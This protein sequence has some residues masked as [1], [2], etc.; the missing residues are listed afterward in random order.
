MTSGFRILGREGPHGRELTPRMG[1]QAWA[2]QS[3][4]LGITRTPSLPWWAEAGLTLRRKDPPCPIDCLALDLVKGNR[5]E[6]GEQVLHLASF[7][8]PTLAVGRG[9]VSHLLLSFDVATC[10]VG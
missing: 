1:Q 6:S 10:E 7:L 2:V 3:W 4:G 9:G 5:L 8:T